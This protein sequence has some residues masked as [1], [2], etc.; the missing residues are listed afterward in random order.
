MRDSSDKA[1]R[2]APSG[3]SLHECPGPYPPGDGWPEV[4]ASSFEPTLQRR[5]HSRHR[6]ILTRDL[7]RSIAI[8]ISLK[9]TI[10]VAK[11][12]EIKKKKK[13]STAIGTWPTPE[14]P[15]PPLASKKRKK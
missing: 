15:T 8:V 4:Q 1:L 11:M 2:A 9:S 5:D 3:Q 12:S 13:P 14:M 10:T 6:R 7:H